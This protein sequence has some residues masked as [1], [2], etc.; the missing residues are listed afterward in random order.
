MLKLLLSALQNGES[1]QTIYVK[2]VNTGDYQIC[3]GLVVMLYVRVHQSEKSTF[4][5]QSPCHYGML[6]VVSHCSKEKQYNYTV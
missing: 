4:T 6:I 1:P 5:N 2:Q 3:L